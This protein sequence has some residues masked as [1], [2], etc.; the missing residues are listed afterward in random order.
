MKAQA[1]IPRQLRMKGGWAPALT[2]R[3]H[4]QTVAVL[5]SF[6]RR[7]LVAK[8]HAYRLRVALDAVRGAVVRKIGVVSRDPGVA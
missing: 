2:L 8:S 3:R 7:Y 1:A 6:V 4:Y 5:A